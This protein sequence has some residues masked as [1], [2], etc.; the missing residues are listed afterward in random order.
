[1]FS[2][3]ALNSNCICEE[4]G[5]LRR[6]WLRQ[7]QGDVSA[8]IRYGFD[9][10]KLDGCGPANDTFLWAKLI[11]ATGK[12]IMIEHCAGM[13]LLTPGGGRSTNPRA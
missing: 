6:N 11:N 2:V 12:P 1:M 10:V 8:L 9:A 4:T 5:K 7:M 13:R 3:A